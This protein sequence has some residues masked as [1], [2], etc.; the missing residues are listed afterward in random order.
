MGE[1]GVFG[2]GLRRDEDL[3]C[4][5]VCAVRVSAAQKQFSTMH[6]GSFL[7]RESML[8]CKESSFELKDHSSG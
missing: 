6:R 8:V 4:V 7:L 5:T 2:R 1:K 3:M